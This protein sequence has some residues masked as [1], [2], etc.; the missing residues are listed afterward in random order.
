MVR[1]G[2]YHQYINIAIGDRS[3]TR[4][5]HTVAVAIVSGGYKNIHGTFTAKC[6]I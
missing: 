3:E 1:N 4:S 5:I 6:N 2:H